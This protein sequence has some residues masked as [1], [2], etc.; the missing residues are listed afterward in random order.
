[1]VC[2][3]I[4][5]W[6]SINILLKLNILYVIFSDKVLYYETAFLTFFSVFEYFYMWEKHEN[7]LTS[8]DKANVLREKLLFWKEKMQWKMQMKLLNYWKGT[9]CIIV[10]LKK[11]YK[12]EI[13]YTSIL[14]SLLQTTHE[15]HAKCI[16]L[17]VHACMLTNFHI[18]WGKL[19]EIR[20]DRRLETRKST[21]DIKAFCLTS[22]VKIYNMYKN[23]KIK[24]LFLFLSVIKFFFL[25]VNINVSLITEM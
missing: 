21:M 18:M 6:I 5:L 25:F 16:V 20:N 12:F 24:L 19:K 17:N 14:K 3:E 15:L 10:F 22:I 11:S 8:S 2:N 13:D 23:N 9:N 7:V 4:F 1:M